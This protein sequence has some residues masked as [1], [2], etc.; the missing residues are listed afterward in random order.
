MTSRAT[1]MLHALEAH[2]G[3]AT[4]SQLWDHAGRF[5][6]TNNAAAELRAAG[7][8]VAYDRDE[9]SYRLLDQGHDDN[10]AEQTASAQAVPLIE[11]TDGQ[12]SL[13]V[14]A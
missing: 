10:G 4:R 11:E 1:T 3:E 12:M 5:Y 9:D 2:N 7:I 8:D 13:E 6:L 14:A